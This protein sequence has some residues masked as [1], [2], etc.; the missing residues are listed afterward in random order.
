MDDRTREILNRFD[1]SWVQTKASFADLIANHKG[2]K[3]LIPVRAFITRLEQS[4]GKELYRLGTSIHILIISRSVDHGLRTDQKY[5]RIEAY[6]ESDF[7]VTMRDGE[8]MY[9]Q[10]R[11]SDLNDSCIIKLFQTLKQLLID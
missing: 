8:K 2:F 1:A 10:Y 11:V 9:R 6:G 4:G 3:R 7:E 5:I